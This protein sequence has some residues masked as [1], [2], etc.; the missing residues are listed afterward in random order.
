MDPTE[1]L[2]RLG[3]DE[4]PTDEELRDARAELTV[5]LRDAVANRAVDEGTHLRRA[6]RS[7]DDELA[8]RA[9]AEAALEANALALLD[10]IE[11]DEPDVDDE[12]DD[13]AD[14]DDDADPHEEDPLDLQGL[15]AASRNARARI[16]A[17]ARPEN[18]R[19]HVRVTSVGPASSE[20]VD[21][22]TT[23]RDL[24]RI[25]AQHARGRD[26]GR[27]TLFSMSW[28]LPEDR[29]LGSNIDESTRM[30]D[31]V[32]NADSTTFAA[33]AAAGGICGPLEALYDIP[34]F[35]V[36]TRPVRDA[37]T[38]F[39]ADRGGIRYVPANRLSLFTPSGGTAVWTAE[40][41][42]NPIEPTEKPCPHIDCKEECTATVDAITACVTVGNF[43][44]RF[45]PEQWANAL[46]MLRVEHARLA[47]QTLLAG[48]DSGSIAATYAGSGTI[49]NVLGAIDRAIA[50][51]RSRDRLGD[52]AFRVIV[53][54]WLRAA[55]RDHFTNQAPSGN[56]GAFAV[57][58]AAVSSWF[59][60]RGATVS[61][62]MDDAIIGAQAA[63]A[64]NDFPAATDI[65]IFPEG[66][67][68][69]LDGGTLDLG[70]EV[71]DQ[72]LIQQN[73]RLAFM[74]TFEG[75]AKRTAP[76]DEP[77]DDSLV[78]TVDIDP[79]CICN[80]VEAAAV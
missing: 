26:A 68:L 74:E 21:H 78:V 75:V 55:L 2:A 8:A 40:N 29:R 59:A 6:V 46:H 7:I 66:T 17:N 1:V 30:I 33:V 62:T 34:N 58:D 51:I 13:E 67:W 10:G 19:P 23:T 61:Y 64:L 9:E 79:A 36:T 4:A 38:R 72:A 45:S 41:D 43:L 53:D 65:R 49:Q 18:P 14:D 11:E 60:A 31:A 27:Q 54:G 77:G 37:L 16:D 50:G 52:T 47:E 15:R 44:A 28:D 69:F 25:F 32:I 57:G 20:H 71:V 12:A 22:D 73:N 5:Q 3:T 63:G 70:T 80:V 76:C 35:G 56:T 42:A 24:G 48:I 39:G